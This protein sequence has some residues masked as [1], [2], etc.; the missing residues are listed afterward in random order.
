MSLSENVVEGYA[1]SLN[2]VSSYISEN[3][4]NPIISFYQTKKEVTLTDEEREALYQTLNDFA[5]SGHI[6]TVASSKKVPKTK[7]KVAKTVKSNGNPPSEENGGDE[8]SETRVNKNDKDQVRKPNGKGW[9]NVGGAAHLK[10]LRAGDYNE[11]TTKEY[12][13]LLKKKTPK[14]RGRNKNSTPNDDR[15]ELPLPSYK[16]PKSKTRKAKT[17]EVGD[18]TELDDMMKDKENEELLELEDDL[19]I[20]IKSKAVYTKKKDGIYLRY[21]CDDGKWR[22]PTEKEMGDVLGHK[23]GGVSVE[24]DY[25]KFHPEEDR[26]KIDQSVDF[27]K[28][29]AD[30]PEELSDDQVEHHSKVFGISYVKVKHTFTHNCEKCDFGS[31]KKTELTAH[32]KKEKH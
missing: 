6:K 8:L 10:Y 7:L 12:G 11:V 5:L 13:D 25:S 18:P 20:G 19:Y 4:V 22:I 30:S 27:L 16:E 21:K 24:K 14:K 23:E 29:I 9:I 15:K 17:E 3:L 26:K 2:T 31:N 1:T 28:V 32:L